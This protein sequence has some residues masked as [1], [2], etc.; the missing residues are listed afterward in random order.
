MPAVTP[1]KT[2]TAYVLRVPDYMNRMKRGEFHW[3]PPNVIGGGLNRA[4]QPLPHSFSI[5]GV[6]F[7]ALDDKEDS[8]VYY[9]VEFATRETKKH[10]DR[11]YLAFNKEHAATRGAMPRQKAREQW[12]S[13]IG[14]GWTPGESFEVDPSMVYRVPLA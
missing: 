4:T 7:I 5:M 2:V 6:W 1:A 11:G 10:G 8:P 14:C 13:L 3:K 12:N 9:F